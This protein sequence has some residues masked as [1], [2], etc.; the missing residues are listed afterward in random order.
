MLSIV[1][2]AL[3]LTISS[4]TADS[5]S[6]HG[7]A[8]STNAASVIDTAIARMG[9]L[10]AL[11]GIKTARYHLAIQWLNPNF[12]SRPY[13]DAPSYEFDTDYR[14]YGTRIWRNTRRFASGADWL[15]PIDVPS[16]AR[17]MLIYVPSM[18]WVYSSG[19]TGPLDQEFIARRIAERGWSVARIGTLQLPSGA[20]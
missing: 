1:G 4:P 2:F 16:T 13:R 18:K 19:L 3:A 14:D 6:R 20:P 10:P 7:T 5:A 9:G 12:D 17:A 11:Q 15:E 8:S